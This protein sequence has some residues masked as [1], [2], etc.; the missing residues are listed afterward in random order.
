MARPIR[1]EYEGA[2]Y[3]I[4]NRGNARQD[5]F[6]TDKDFRVFLKVLRELQPGLFP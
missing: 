5:I 4:T 2:F 3:H 6:H 1:I